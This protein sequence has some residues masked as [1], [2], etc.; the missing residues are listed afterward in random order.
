MALVERPLRM[1]KAGGSIPSVSTFWPFHVGWGSGPGPNDW[2]RPPS[3]FLFTDTLHCHPVTINNAQD[4]PQSHGESVT[5]SEKRCCPTVGRTVGRLRRVAEPT[6]GS[7]GLDPRPPDPKP[8]TALS[9]LVVDVAFLSP[10]SA[11]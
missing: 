1:R 3:H 4:R 8:V 5:D 9:S 11:L 7:Q 6:A 2:T 10:L